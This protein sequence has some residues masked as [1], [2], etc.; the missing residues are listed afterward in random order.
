MIAFKWKSFQF[1][2]MINIWTSKNSQIG[3]VVLRIFK[4]KV[5]QG[6]SGLQATFYI[7]II[8]IFNAFINVRL[9][10][11]LCFQSFLL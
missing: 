2:T 6:T 1:R 8:C 9:M 10:R 4:V 3:K 11:E 5:S 7:A